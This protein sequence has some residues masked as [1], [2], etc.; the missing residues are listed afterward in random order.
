[1]PWSPSRELQAARSG[2]PTPP[3]EAAAVKPP[4]L[5]HFLGRL[6]KQT[7]TQPLWDFVFSRADNTYIRLHPARGEPKI[8]I[9]EVVRHRRPPPHEP[10]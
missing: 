4:P 7:V 9:E 3:P 5:Y 10:S 1:M 6:E 8:A 2:K